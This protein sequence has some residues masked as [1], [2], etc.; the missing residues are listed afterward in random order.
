MGHQHWWGGPLSLLVLHV[1]VPLYALAGLNCHAEFARYSDAS[2]L[3]FECGV[4]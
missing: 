4:D 1:F 2:S 3:F